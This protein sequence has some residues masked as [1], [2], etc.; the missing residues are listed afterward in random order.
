MIEDGEV[1]WKTLDGQLDGLVAD[2]SAIE[3]EGAG[4]YSI[5]ILTFIRFDDNG[6]EYAVEPNEP[7]NILK[8][9]IKNEV[10]ETLTAL[11]TTTY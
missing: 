10:S 2:I 11:F 7:E 8:V 3:N 5:A 9:R 4:K 1:L 6:R